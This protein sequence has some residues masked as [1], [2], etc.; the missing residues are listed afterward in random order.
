MGFPP[1]YAVS[2]PRPLTKHKSEITL[3]IK[4]FFYNSFDSNAL[5]CIVVAWLGFIPCQP[6]VK[7]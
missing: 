7:P 4:C 1:E 5:L 3:S 2:L 6:R